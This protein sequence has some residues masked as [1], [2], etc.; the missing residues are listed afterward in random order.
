MTDYEHVQTRRDGAILIATLVNPP[1]NLM[2][3]TMVSELTA[4]ATE[5]ATSEDVRV[6]I[7]T[8]AADGIFITHYDVGELSRIS[9]VVRERP[10]AA[11][12]PTGGPA[13]LH[14][15][16]KLTLQLQ[17]LPQPV[18]AAI[19][20]T[21]MGGGCELT[22][23]CD[24]RI[25]AKGYQLGLPEVRVGILPGAG[26]TQRMTRLLGTAKALELMLL[27]NTV[28]ADEAARIGLIHRA[29]EPE[30]VLDEAL[31]LATELASRPRT[32]IAEIKRCIL[33]GVQMPLEDALRFEQ[34]AFN[35]TMRSD[36]AARLM[37]AYLRSERPLNE[38]TG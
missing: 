18:I 31:M 6:L 19:N 12:A 5:L 23:G 16:N 13:E 34:E 33:Q 4:I 21:A 30:R 22:L 14:A 38:Q 32:S 9:D 29:V 2:N 10:D 35:R 36:D 27:G 28:D 25:M 37:R 17:A 8:G 26:G 20:G 11:P 15:L 24:F 3:A 7:L 1:R